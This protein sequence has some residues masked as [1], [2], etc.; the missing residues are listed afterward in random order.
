MFCDRF[1]FNSCWSGNVDD[2]R[3]RYDA[4]FGVSVFYCSWFSRHEIM[5]KK[6]QA[7]D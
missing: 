5:K 3:D 1:R 4:Y 7:P 6:T 2:L